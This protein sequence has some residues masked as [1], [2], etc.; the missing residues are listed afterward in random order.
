MSGHSKWSQ[1]KRQKGAADLKRGAAFSK[2]TNAIIIAAR[3]G[4][5]P[6]SNFQL[7][8]AIEKARTASMPKETIDRA[9]KR[10]TGELAGAK[11]EE[12]LYEAIGPSGIGILIEAVTDNRNRTNSE[13]KNVLTSFSGKLTGSGAVAYQ[14]ERMGKFLI[15]L[16]GKNREELELQIIDA[17]ATDFEEQEDVLEIYTKPAE[18][19]IVKKAIEAQGI[20]IREPAL[21][22]EPKNTIEISD[23][24]EAEKILKLMETLDILEDVIAVYSNFEISPTLEAG[25]IKE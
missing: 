17:G 14:F 4:G 9:I 7:K 10:G 11:V 22:W 24:N 1:I 12:I 20:E 21:T 15:D 3:Q 6:N 25:L 19:E 5:D 16:S 13:V 8:M 23:K 2:L 18:L